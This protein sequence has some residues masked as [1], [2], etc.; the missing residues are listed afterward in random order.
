MTNDKLKIP[1]G[2][3]CCASRFVVFEG[4][5][6]TA[7]PSPFVICHL[8][9]VILLIS[10]CLP[11]NAFGDGGSVQV[12]SVSGPF[13]ITLFAEPPLPRA[14]QIDFSALIQDA[15]S[16]QPV[17]DAAVTLALTPVKVHQNAQPAWYPPSCAV[18]APAD[19]A[20]V[21]L[22]HSGASNRLLYGAMVE[23]PAAG[24]WHVRAEIQ[25]GDEHVSVEGNVDIADPFPPIASYWPL[26]LFPAVAIGLYVLREQ[27]QRA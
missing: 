26:F 15:K 13:E 16:S 1:H 25:R 20:A 4:Q 6:L 7:R 12:H 11:G 5:F 18:S 24:V 2:G 27:I 17:M 23:I 14:G 8:S 10:L 3:S 22:L 21:P 9:F 19:L